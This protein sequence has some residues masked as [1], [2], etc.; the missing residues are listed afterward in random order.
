MNKRGTPLGGVRKTNP[1][2][3]TDPAAVQRA[4]RKAARKR[5]KKAKQQRERRQREAKEDREVAKYFTN[6]VAATPHVFRIDPRSP[7]ST[8]PPRVTEEGRLQQRQ[9]A[10]DELAQENFTLH[11]QLTELKDDYRKLADKAQDQELL[12]AWEKD[13]TQRGQDVFVQEAKSLKCLLLTLLRTVTEYDASL[14]AT[15]QR[16]CAA[17]TRRP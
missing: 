17:A 14:G 12:R 8:E 7:I 15:L 1:F 2:L 3:S 4:Q 5:A 11:T 10:Y 13:L 16:A 9:L 6:K